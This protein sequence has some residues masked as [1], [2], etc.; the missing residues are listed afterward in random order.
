MLMHGDIPDGVFVLHKPPCNTRHC[1]LHLY[2]GTQK[3]NVHD[4]MMM[5]TIAKGERNWQIAHPE[6]LKRG[7]AHHSTVIT[8]EMVDAIQSLGSSMSRKA[9]AAKFGI[10]VP[11]VSQIQCCQYQRDDLVYKFPPNNRLRG[12]NHHKA[13]LTQENVDEMRALYATGAWSQSALGHYFGVA[14]ST[15]AGIVRGEEWNHSPT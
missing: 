15:A 5:G 12:G 6:K 4:E 11:M 3:E 13:K 10:S 8:Q 7:L 9:M 14:R 1:V 2:T